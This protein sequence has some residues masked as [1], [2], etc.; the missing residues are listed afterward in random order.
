MLLKKS[1]KTSIDITSEIEVLNYTY[2]NTDE[3]PIISRVDITNIIGNGRYYVNLY[4]NDQEVLPSF[5][6]S[7]ANG[8]TKLVA[9]S[10][11][12]IIVKNDV[13]S[14]RV[15]G[16]S[17]DTSINSV[18]YLVSS[19]SEIDD[20]AIAEAIQSAMS[21][22][23]LRPERVVFGPCRK[24]VKTTYLELPRKANNSHLKDLS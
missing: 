2:T 21:G 23:E 1:I 18:A 4:I 12:F 14:I 13:I 8:Q 5:S 9:Q 19:E 15:V 7:V 22:L 11:Q 20:S 3:I 6:I 10:K 17:G 24:S 16:L